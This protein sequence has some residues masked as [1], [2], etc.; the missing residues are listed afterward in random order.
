MILKCKMCGGD[1]IVVEGKS[2]C[3]CTYCG[4][5]QTV[6]S[7]D[8]EKK[9]T[10][11]SRANR[12]RAL[13]EFDKAY[14]VY[15]NI[16]VDFP[17][18]AEAYWGLVLCKYGIEYVDD[19]VT[20]KRVPTCHRSSFDNVMEDSNF[21]MVME[22]ADAE[23]KP[24]YRAEAKEIERLRSGILEV[25]SKEQP[26]DIF[27]CYK[28]TDEKGNRTVDSVIAQDVYTALTE[29]G[30]RVFFSRIT[31]E[32]KL[33]QEY[34]PYIFA[35]LH[36]AK[37]M[38]AFG[39]SYD[40]YNAVWVKNEWSR[41]LALIAKGEKKIL[42][43]CYKDIDA[44]DMPPEFKKLQAQDMGKVGA[45]QDLLRGIEKLLPRDGKAESTTQVTAPAMDRFLKRG[46]QCLEIGQMKEA[47]KYFTD[48]LNDF[49]EDPRGWW[50]IALSRTD[51][52]RTI[53]ANDKLFENAYRNA[54]KYT[55]EKSRQQL[56]KTVQ[57]VSAKE[58]QNLQRSIS[59]TR[60]DISS[61]E[62]ELN[63][64]KAGQTQKDQAIA[65][66]QKRIED[67]QA[68]IKENEAIKSKG[69]AS[70]GRSRVDY[71]S[72]CGSLVL[73]WILSVIVAW[74][75]SLFVEDV[76]F[77]VVIIAFVSITIL[78]IIIWSSVRSRNVRA[79]EADD[80]IRTLQN[81]ISE[82]QYQIQNE[83]RMNQTPQI[84]HTIESKIAAGKAQI[85]AYNKTIQWYSAL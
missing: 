19:P 67:K 46:H 7:L 6:P 54:M 40:Y 9:I 55:S 68:A 24:V 28:E 11:F 29:K 44:Y 10:L 72:G 22:Y 52:M 74:I 83:Q 58:I 18:E 4:S 85:E 78:S 13:G 50:G 16:V 42:I 8:S 39:T 75:V 45:I 80:T 57:G 71:G 59:E 38:L 73:I 65:R 35:A 36:S 41:F 32:D 31:L 64:H 79:A 43:P 56:S 76:P 63:R 51:N 17:E 27:I 26:Y 70:S 20:G 81:E 15:E 82:L 12:L 33:G 34:E 69:D 53:P 37:V 48:Y 2:I 49:P 21:G 25:S 30:Y 1:L 62:A 60:K 14:S 61:L 23:A 47:E 84:I 77:A 5:K 3:E 66:L